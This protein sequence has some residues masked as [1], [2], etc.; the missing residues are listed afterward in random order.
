[1]N[2]NKTKPNS[3]NYFIS[4]RKISLLLLSIVWL[5]GGLILLT[6][7]IFMIISSKE[8]PPKLGAFS[9]LLPVAI[10]IA[11]GIV[12]AQVVFK[13]ISQKNIIKSEKIKN[14]FLDYSFGWLR[15][16]GPKNMIIISSMIVLGIVLSKVL[17]D[18][19]RGLVK[20]T[21]GTALT[22]STFNYFPTIKNS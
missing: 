5:T 15:V 14:N 2:N 6:G 4:A 13:K 21:I 10:S 20:L 17:P 22:L 7:G 18:F 16:L 1:M 12:K 8:K 19:Y 11:L 9:Y 3:N